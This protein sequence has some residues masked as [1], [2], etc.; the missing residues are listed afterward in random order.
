MST[1]LPPLPLLDG[2]MFIDNSGWME[3]ISICK[4]LLEYRSLRQRISIGEKPALN[5]GSAIHLALEYRYKHYR[6]NPV[7]EAFY[8]HISR[9]LTTFFE[10]HPTPIDDWRDLNWAMNLLRQYNDKYSVEDFSLLIG[11]DGNPL[12]ELPFVIELYL[13]QSDAIYARL[14]P[15]QQIWY[16]KHNGLR[17]IYTGK[18][19]LPT[20]YNEGIWVMDHK[21]SSQL[22]PT[23]F[24]K[25]KMSAQQRGYCWAFER[26]T[27]QKVTGYRVNAIRSKQPP[28]YV[29]RGEESRKTG[30]RLSVS[31]WWNESLARENYVLQ[32]SHVS[33]WL[34]NAIHL[35][36]EF[37]YNY[38]HDYLPMETAYACSA[39]GKCQYVDVCE[40]VEE[41]RLGM[42]NS[43][44]YTLNEWTPLKQ[45]SQSKQ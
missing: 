5:F 4:R 16:R 37:F 15:A 44:M 3:S 29:L 43:G 45:P 20:Y 32:P 35:V 7:D 21:T 6:H 12:V 19:D 30:K 17:I 24:L 2:C 10:L 25:M 26:L 13:H 18:I 14:T 23:F 39:W 22:G 1:P 33:E 40:M 11:A 36:E 9:E 31:D 41:E 8:A 28:L 34:T 42:L 38:S 27:G